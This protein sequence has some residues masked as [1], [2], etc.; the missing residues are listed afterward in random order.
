MNLLVDDEE[1]SYVTLVLEDD[2]LNYS[3]PRLPDCPPLTP[4]SN[5]HHLP[6]RYDS[7]TS[8]S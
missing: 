5:L 7:E 2:G 8:G 3:V 1:F 6:S 4:P